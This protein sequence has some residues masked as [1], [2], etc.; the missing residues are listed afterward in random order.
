MLHNPLERPT[1]QQALQLL[2]GASRGRHG[3][4]NACF[5][6]LVLRLVLPLQAE[7][8]FQGGPLTL[9]PGYPLLP[10]P[11]ALLLCGHFGG[12]PIQFFL[13]FENSTDSKKEEEALKIK[14]NDL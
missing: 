8:L 14:T 6:M 7:F 13:K 10:L 11:L 9:P 3:C 12:F 2:L 5:V 4:V 1:A